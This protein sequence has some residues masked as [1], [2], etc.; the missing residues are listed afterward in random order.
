MNIHL[1]PLAGV[2]DLAFRTIIN[3]YGIF[4]QKPATT[5]TEMI[6]SRGLYYGD[7]KTLQLLKTTDFDRQNLI[8]QIFGNQPE[9]MAHAAD[10][11]LHM[12]FEHIDINCGCPARKIVK[13]GDGGALLA[14]PK[15]IGEII[16]AVVATGAKTSVKIRLDNSEEVIKRAI[17]AGAYRITLHGR[18]IA[19]EYR[20]NADWGAIVGA[21]IGRQR[22]AEGGVPYKADG[23][24]TSVAPHFE[25]QHSPKS[26]I[27]NPVSFIGNGDITSLEAAETIS[28]ETGIED[29]MVGRG[30]LKLDKAHALEHLSLIHE[31]KGAHGIFEARRV[32]MYYHTDKNL[33][34]KLVKISDYNEMRELIELYKGSGCRIQDS[35]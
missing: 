28:N 12:G 16:K 3:K 25:E 4:G 15:L 29:I 10:K 21:T 1:A 6:A 19:Q 27:L 33:R 2:T 26:R 20:G 17:D 22:D 7:K 13:N 35:D 31:H 11:L 24:P 23:H 34:T 9:I 32:M 8:V 5:T 30:A 14:N 18:T